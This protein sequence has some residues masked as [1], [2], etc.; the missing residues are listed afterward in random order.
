MFMAAV[1]ADGAML[2]IALL[3]V[4]IFLAPGALGQAT[5]LEVRD[6][7]GDVDAPVPCTMEFYDI[8]GFGMNQTAPEQIWCAIAFDGGFANWDLVGSQTDWVV[9]VH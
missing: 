9:R 6:T 5:G 8:A 7:V 3:A 1:P 2:V 4:T